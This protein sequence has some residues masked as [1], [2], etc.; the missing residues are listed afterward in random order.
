MKCLA[1]DCPGDAF[2]KGLCYVHHFGLL[3]RA[4]PGVTPRQVNSEH[5][6]TK[7]KEMSDATWREKPATE[8]QLAL[9]ERLG[10]KG[11]QPR[12]AGDA[13]DAIDR[14]APPPTDKQLNFLDD[15]GYDGE[16]PKSK[17]DASKLI[18]QL[19]EDAA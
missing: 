8:K 6:E 12:T 9:L 4:D 16:P 18:D 15:L 5:A 2:K 13:A 11:R 19:L 7:E 14:L 1:D 10:H 17:W 3:H